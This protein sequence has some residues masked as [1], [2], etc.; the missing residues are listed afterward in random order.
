MNI[1]NDTDD[2]IK[3]LFKFE[4]ID[5]LC[6]ERAEMKYVLDYPLKGV[7]WPNNKEERHNLFQRDSI[8]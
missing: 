7:K 8:S 4:L 2:I 3:D 1:M 5:S 6:R